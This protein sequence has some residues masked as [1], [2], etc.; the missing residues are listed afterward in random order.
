MVMRFPFY[1]S[2]THHD[3]INY[4]VFAGWQ[5]EKVRPD[6]KAWLKLDVF[7]KFLGELSTSTEG[8][9]S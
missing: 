1:F 9:L 8:V 7:W 6:L 4:F 3:D 5:R 2:L